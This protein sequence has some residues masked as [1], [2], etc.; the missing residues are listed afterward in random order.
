[1][2]KMKK[3]S[4]KWAFALYIIPCVII[5]MAGILIIGNGTNYLQELYLSLHS[6]PNDPEVS[7]YEIVFHDY[8]FHYSSRLS[9]RKESIIYM[10]ISNAQV[11]LMPIWTIF[12]VGLTGLIFYNIELKKPIKTLMDASR[13]ISENQLDFQIKRQKNNEL[14]MLCDAFEDMRGNHLRKESV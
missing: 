12:C 8:A 10:I 3:K 11:V 1:M 5:T 2:G 13:K 9:S 4:L 6:S 7:Y 14:G